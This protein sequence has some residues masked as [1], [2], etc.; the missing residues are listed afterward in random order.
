MMP[1]STLLAEAC[2]AFKP[3]LDPGACQLVYQKKPLDPSLPFRFANL[4]N[5][6][7]LE[8][9]KCGFLVPRPEPHG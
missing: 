4:P 5:G 6:S 8:V 9:V 2:A 7:R 1:L 3:P